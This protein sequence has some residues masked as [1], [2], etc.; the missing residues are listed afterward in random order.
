D[1]RPRLAA[2]EGRQAVLQARQVGGDRLA[3]KIGP[4]RQQ[5]SELDEARAHFGERRGQ[6]LARARLGRIGTASEQAGDA[7]QRGSSGN[8]IQREQ[9][10]VPREGQANSDK[11]NEV[12][13]AAQKPERRLTRK[14]V[15]KLQ[16]RQAEWSAATPPVRV[17]NLTCSRPARAIISASTVCR[18]KPRMLSTR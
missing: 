18:G 15:G 12:A 2:R 17:R 7:Q 3:E 6:P 10:V 9:R 14:P 5:L 16:R 1:Q 13:G 8:R 4:G 11:A